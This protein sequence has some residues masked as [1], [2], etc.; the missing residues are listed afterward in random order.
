MEALESSANSTFCYNITNRWIGVRLDL[1]CGC[2]AICTSIFCIAA[3]NTISSDLLIFSLQITL[4]VVVF[5]SISIRFGTEVHNYMSSSQKI[6]QYTQLEL[7]DELVKETDKKLTVDGHWPPRGQVEFKNVFMKYRETMEPSLKGL[8]F[9]AQAGMKIGVVGRTGAGKSSILQALFRLSDSSEGSIEIDGVNIKDVGLHLLRINI[10]YIPQAPFLIQGSIREN[11]DPFE[12]YS[13][14]EAIAA[15]KEVHLM[16]HIEN[17]CDHGMYTMVS[18]SNS[19]F[20]M[21]QKQLLCL[22]RAIIRKTKMLVLDE[23]TANVDLET[24]NFIQE[25]LQESFKNCTVVIIAHRLA[26]VIDADRILVM[27]DGVGKEFDH[28][29]KLL[30]NDEA[31]QAITSPG[32]FAEM[33]QATGGN[34]ALSLFKIAREKYLQYR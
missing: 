28:P 14:E 2:I 26:T 24:D 13:E 31:D 3:K 16:E 7:E 11:L 33:V 12:E 1:V 20:S 32:L 5:F 8:N 21:G 6:Y 29:F 10:A 23:A 15:L 4:D 19:L 17:N 30:V 18:E 22:A 27:A 9:K 25:K 34:T